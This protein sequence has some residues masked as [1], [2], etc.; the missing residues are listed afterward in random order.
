MFIENKN[1][2]IDNV[3]N[4]F[5]GKAKSIL[6]DGLKEK[7]HLYLQSIEKETSVHFNSTEGIDF[8]TRSSEF[9]PYVKLI[10]IIEIIKIVK[11]HIGNYENKVGVDF[12][13]GS[14]QLR[15]V[16][17]SLSDNFGENFYT[18]D[19][20]IKQ[21]I[22]GL[23]KKY[24]M[25]PCDITN[26]YII[27]NNSIDWALIA[28]GF[29]HI[30]PNKRITSLR[31][32]YDKVRSGGILVLHDGFK[33]SS[34]IDIM[35]KVVDV[36]S[37][38][39]HIYPFLKIEDFDKY[40]DYFKS[41]FNANIY[42]YGIY[43]PQIFIGESLSSTIN[44]FSKYMKYHYYLDIEEDCIFDIFKKVLLEYSEKEH[45]SNTRKY[46]RLEEKNL[47]SASCRY[48][49][50]ENNN[51]KA[52]ALNLYTGLCPSDISTEYTKVLKID[53]KYFNNC[54]IVPRFAHILVIEKK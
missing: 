18:A 27:K 11:R 23:N 24:T 5:N 28:Y 46:L 32:V 41:T 42:R 4:N 22:Q 40:G 14:G 33:G 21:I 19:K 49:F 25:I 44:Q 38:E 39:K 45:D 2:I 52:N 12:L 36:Y 43:D 54:L 1:E 29:H 9:S 51:R 10:G 26:P 35:E 3:F 17:S 7:L 30:Q 31:A 15:K 8:Y 50:D 37:K 16:I 47:T 48:V 34:T 53:E 20:S 6:V 13:G